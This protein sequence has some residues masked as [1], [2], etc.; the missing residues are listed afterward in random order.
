MPPAT[1]NWTIA[2]ASGVL[3][4]TTPTASFSSSA[5]RF[6]SA[7][8]IGGMI[9][10]PSPPVVSPSVD[11]R[12][13]RYATCFA[14]GWTTWGWQHAAA[15]LR[16]DDAHSQ[17][18]QLF[19]SDGRNAAGQTVRYHIRLCAVRGAAPTVTIGAVRHEASTGFLADTINCN[20][21]SAEAFVA[22]QLCGS[23]CDSA[24]LATQSLMQGGPKWRGWNNGAAAT[25]VP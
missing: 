7:S 5:T 6:P 4:F 21:E 2:P 17:D 25:V 13:R 19:R 11:A 12:P 9:S 16:D 1:L 3:P 20:W 18:Q 15:A 23:E 10:W 8:G 22:G 14:K 24:A